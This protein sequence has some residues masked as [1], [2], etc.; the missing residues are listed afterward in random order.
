MKK[1][2]NQLSSL[3]LALSHCRLTSQLVNNFIEEGGEV[4]LIVPR[5]LS[6]LDFT[7]YLISRCIP[8]SK[9]SA[10]LVTADFLMIDDLPRSLEIYLNDFTTYTVQSNLFKGFILYRHINF[11]YL[12]SQADIATHA[13]KYGL[14]SIIKYAVSR[15]D[16]MNEKAAKKAIEYDHLEC[17]KY[18]IHPR[19]CS[20]SFDI[21]ACAAFNGRDTH[22]EFLLDQ[23]EFEYK[24]LEPIWREVE[25]GYSKFFN[26]VS[27]NDGTEWAIRGDDISFENDYFNC[28]YIL[29]L[30]WFRL[31]IGVAI[32]AAERGH[33]RL[34]RFLGQHGCYFNAYVIHAAAENGH[35][36]CLKYL[37][38]MRCP[39]HREIIKLAYENG[40]HECVSFLREKGY[41]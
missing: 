4:E 33:H 18:L 19:R 39:W 10:A 13:A 6:I 27:C 29:T 25:R 38:Q 16:E 37:Y 30:R 11:A 26:D 5:G 8:R 15:G 23:Y 17:L 20:L 14:L 9:F 32:R 1:K 2:M 34:L 12:D 36:G 35:L 31:D 7:A 24:W 3:K 21:V 40:H 28:F 22:L 41:G